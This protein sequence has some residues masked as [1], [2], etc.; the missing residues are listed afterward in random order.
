M[1]RMGTHARVLVAAAVMAVVVAGCGKREFQY[2]TNLLANH[3]FEEVGG[4]GIPKGWSLLP[5][6]GGEG[7][8]EVRYGVDDKV[9]QDGTHSWY[10]RAD[11]GTQRFHVLGQEVEVADDA[12]HVRL[13]GW[14]QLDGVELNKGQ[15]AHCNFL[16]TFFDKDHHRFQ[17]MRV[18]DKR[19]HVRNG[20]QLWTEEDQTFRLPKGTRYVQF[21][22]VLGM[23]GSVWFDNV[24]LSVPKP[25]PWEEAATKNFVFHWLPGHPMPQGSQESQQQIFDAIAA[26]LGVESDVVIQYYFYPDTTTIREMLSLKGY[27]YASWDDY[28]FHSIN[29]N[30]NHE[31]VHFMTDPVGRPPRAI[32][33]GT[34]FW[35]TQDWD[36][37]PLDQQMRT[38]V[39]ARKVP[40]LRSVLDYNALAMQDPNITFPATASFIG[41]IVDRW[42]TAKLLELYKE[43]NGV[44][45]YDVFAVAFEKVYGIPL[46]EVETA[47]KERLAATYSGK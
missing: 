29:P 25:T 10:F 3:S 13:T 11:P 34:V 18:A 27:Q 17:E 31:V 22:C 21:S 4:D 41:F 19:T 2:D 20:A 43:T 47:W 8:S 15:Y 7:Q 5:F 35:I 30:D 32:A 12:T 33:E 39:R 40:D 45:S 26:R 46:A 36:G 14:M 38:I 28:E 24:S 23:N 44:N 9:A 42:G 16:L 6:R 1:I 37:V